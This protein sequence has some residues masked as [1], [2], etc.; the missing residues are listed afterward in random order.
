LPP[1][2][3][4]EGGLV[5]QIGQVGSG[6]P[7]G[8]AGEDL[9]IDV[10]AQRLASGVNA[11][12]RLP[13]VDVGC[14]DDD[15]TIEAAR[16]EQGRVEDVGTVRR[17]HHDHPGVALEAVELDQELVQGLLPLVVAATK[18]GATVTPDGVDLV[19]EDNGRC[20]LLGL[21][22]EVTDTGGADADEHLDE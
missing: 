14:V 11:E 17:R 7:G 2:G 10:F 18:A 22:E 1:A 16:A 19:D 9:E 6:E 3:G 4:E 21:L 15:L 20:A 13:S 12:D 8:A 5:D